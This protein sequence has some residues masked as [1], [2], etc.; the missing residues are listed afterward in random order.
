MSAGRRPNPGRTLMS[1]FGTRPNRTVE[2]VDL[3]DGCTER[4]LDRRLLLIDERL[5]VAGE[6]DDTVNTR[7]LELGDPVVGRLLEVADGVRRLSGGEESIA[8][9][10]G[11][12][13]SVKTR[14]GE[15][16]VEGNERLGRDTRQLGDRCY[17]R[18]DVRREVSLER[19]GIVDGEEVKALHGR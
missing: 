4:G 3:G 2:G 9:V 13:E 15:S 6:E 5:V 19:G 17:D 12:A 1:S 14:L 8:N 11:D 10:V 18:S 16:N 7:G